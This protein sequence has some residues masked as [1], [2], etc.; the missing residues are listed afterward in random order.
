MDKNDII[1]VL[2]LIGTMLEIKGENPFKVRAYFSGSRTLQTLEEDLGTVIEEGRLGDIPGIGKALTEKIETLFTTGELEFLDKLKASVPDG[3]L[4][5]LEV[6]GLGGKKINALHQKL[7]IDSIESLTQACNDGR[8]AELKG[9]GTKTQDK[10]LSGIENREAYAA[11]H[12]WWDARRVADRILP[13]LQGLPEVD[14]VE[15]AGSLRRGM[16]TVGDLDFLVA[17]SKPEPIMEWFTQMEGIVEVTAHGDTKSSVRFEGGMQAD[18]RVVPSEQ[19]YFALHHF[20]GSKD[21]NVRMRQKALSMGLSLSEWGLRPEEEKDSSRSQGTVEAHSEEDI[22]KTLGLAYIPPS[23]REGM[24]EVEAAEKNE[25]PELL[26]LEDLR[27]CF[28]NHTTA[29]DGR[30]T[31]EEIAAEADKRGWQYLGVADHSKSSFQANG[32]DEARLEK[33]VEAIRV[34]NESGSFSSRI[35]AGSEVDILSGGTLDFS[36]SVLETL[37]YVV[38]SVHNGLTQDEETM[39]NRIIKALEHPKVTMLGHVSGRLLLKREASKMNIQKI[40]DAAIANHK[41]IELNANPMRLDMDWR[42]WRKAAEKGL[43]CAINPDAHALPHYD[44][45]LTGVNIARKGWLTRKHVFNTRSLG[46]VTQYFG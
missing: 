28:H 41:I 45:Q 4:E 31:L 43:L 32:L 39:T 15:A 14:R 33:Q 34:L 5:L 29:S 16:E 21:H 3:L 20:T 30:N 25:L 19:F 44:F 12:L 2:D 1:G 26:E 6:P 35:F 23:L 8:V 38:A 40:I 11:R 17:S 37:D 22:F 9:F 46:E 24:G 36:D 7:G 27:G 10:I 13:G 18:L 42:H